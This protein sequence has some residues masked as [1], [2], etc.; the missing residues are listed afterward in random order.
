MVI[1]RSRLYDMPGTG[2]V[3][4]RFGAMAAGE[5]P[6]LLRLQFVAHALGF[7]ENSE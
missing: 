7:P 4:V 2:E 5:T 1:G 3:L 6:A